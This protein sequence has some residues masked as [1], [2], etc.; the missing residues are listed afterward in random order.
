MNAVCIGAMYSSQS[1]SSQ[2][3]SPFPVGGNR[4]L[5]TN[6]DLLAAKKEFLES[7]QVKNNTEHNDAGV[8]LVFDA[9]GSDNPRKKLLT[10]KVKKDQLQAALGFLHYYDFS[11]TK[12]QF[13]GMKVK[14]LTAAIL[15]KYKIL[16]PDICK[17][18]KK[19]YDW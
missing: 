9:L 4:P 10:N 12:D 3:Q 1:Q 14:E 6:D 2:S 19:I 13:K 5:P 16:Q 15:E 8:N 18:C 17:G 7:L 11:T